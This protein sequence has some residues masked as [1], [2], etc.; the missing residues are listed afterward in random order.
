MAPAATP[1]FPCGRAAS[2]APL[3]PLLP[4]AT[5]DGLKLPKLST[6]GRLV[7]KMPFSLGIHHCPN[8]TPKRL[9]LNLLL[10]FA[11]SRGMT[12]IV[13]RRPAGRT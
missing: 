6:I 4:P 1:A 3:P 10:P 12:V 2:A 9:I 13:S 8:G 7:S 5:Y 11:T